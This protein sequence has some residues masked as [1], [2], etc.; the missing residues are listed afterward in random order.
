LCDTDSVSSRWLI[1]LH[2]LLNASSLSAPAAKSKIAAFVTTLRNIEGRNVRMMYQS[3]RNLTAL[4]RGDDSVL[5]AALDLLERAMFVHRQTHPSSAHAAM[6][7]LLCAQGQALLESRTADK[8]AE[9]LEVYVE[10]F[11]MADVVEQLQGEEG[12]ADSTLGQVAALIATAAN[13]TATSTATN[14]KFDEARKLLDQ[15][16]ATVIPS[17]AATSSSPPS[18]LQTDCRVPFLRAQLAW[19]HAA[20]APDTAVRHLVDA[21]DLHMANHANATAA[22]A[23]SDAEDLLSS[24]ADDDDGGTGA[25]LTKKLPLSAARVLEPDFFPRYQPSLLLD[26][27]RLYLDIIGGLDAFIVSAEEELHEN[28]LL[29]PLI[30]VLSR[31]VAL[32]PGHVGAQLMLA[33]L[34]FLLRD[35]AACRGHIDGCTDMLAHAPADDAA[36]TNAKAELAKLAKMLETRNAA[37]SASRQHHA[38]RRGGAPSSPSDI[39]SSPLFR[40]RTDPV[41]SNAAVATSAAASSSSS[42]RSSGRKPGKP[43]T[44]VAG[45]DDELE[46]DDDFAAFAASSPAA[47]AVAASAARAAS[48]QDVASKARMAALHHAAAQEVRGAML[49]RKNSPS[50][51]Q[52]SLSPHQSH[53]NLLVVQTPQ[54]LTANHSDSSSSLLALSHNS[55]TA[56]LNSSSRP[57]TASG[58]RGGAGGGGGQHGLGSSASA[59]ALGINSWSSVRGGNASGLGGA[60]ASSMSLLHH[61]LNASDS[62]KSV[63]Y[64]RIGGGGI[65]GGLFGLSA[66]S[67]LASLANG[68]AGAAG[69]GN[70]AA[71]TNLASPPSASSLTYSAMFE[72]PGAGRGGFPSGDG[73]SPSS[74][75]LNLS[76][77]ASGFMDAQPQPPALPQPTRPQ[78]PQSPPHPARSSATAAATPIAAPA[79]SFMYNLSPTHL[80]Q[81]AAAAS[82][83][84]GH[85]SSL[86][87]DVLS[88]SSAASA[89]SVLPSSSSNA[90]PRSPPPN[91]SA[92]VTPRT[93]GNSTAATPRSAGVTPRANANGAPGASATIAGATGD[94]SARGQ[95]SARLRALKAAASARVAE[96]EAA[97]HFLQVAR[98]GATFWKHGRS[99]S[100]HERTVRL[101]VFIAS[102][103][104]RH[105]NNEEGEGWG[106]PSDELRFDWGSDRMTLRRSEWKL[107]LGKQTEVFLRDTARRS[108][109]ELCFSLVGASRTLDL[110]ARNSEQRTLWVEGLMRLMHQSAAEFAAAAEVQVQAASLRDGNGGGDGGGAVMGNFMTGAGVSTGGSHSGNNS[111][112]GASGSLSGN[113]SARG[114]GGGGGGA[115][116][117]RNHSRTGSSA[118]NGASFLSV[119]SPGGG[120]SSLL[121]SRPTPPSTQR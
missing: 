65:S 104:P 12:G 19:R 48:I 117:A 23:S 98:H 83:F 88:S 113:N 70:A 85:A 47:A 96:A 44:V 56:S 111:A 84:R 72:G 25:S 6:A 121:G 39:V 10:A 89:N 52:L 2:T 63:G 73:S 100:P 43:Q 120:G 86:S 45:F 5:T 40:S 87:S 27:A 81:P 62:N 1:A 119:K 78:Q 115:D 60:G 79:S 29:R 110:E 64:S 7:R 42:R 94:G 34:C 58:N 99:G 3:A 16:P 37:A 112:R 50:S 18:A 49:T 8:E 75:P 118:R 95:E 114:G 15:L 26:M 93:A 13:T 105:N 59:A 71:T 28:T 74:T 54:A 90:S 14:N 69:G 36:A 108:K 41:A 57:S 82:S 55:S 107:L 22:S 97:A 102:S 9:A 46:L 24:A 92:A 109:P 53:T 68:P 32:V 61:H 67:S 77:Q 116:S 103:S 11:V 20:D 4:S 76:R 33:R 106:H 51:H 17:S 38:S 91:S 66:S 21:L 35:D 31:L 80:A 101:E 30:A